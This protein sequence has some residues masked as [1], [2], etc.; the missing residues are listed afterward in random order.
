MGIPLI[1]KMSAEWMHCDILHK[2]F[3]LRLNV[4]FFFILNFFYAVVKVWGKIDSHSWH[5]QYKGFLHG[6]LDVGFNVVNTCN[7]CHE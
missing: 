1:K 2:L 6:M 5:R 7:W 4:V 3:K